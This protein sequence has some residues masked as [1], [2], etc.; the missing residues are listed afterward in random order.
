LRVRY[1]SRV[2]AEIVLSLIET[3]RK[4][5]LT[6]FTSELFVHPASLP[7]LLH[8]F[9]FP[10]TFLLLLLRSRSFLSRASTEVIR[11]PNISVLFVQFLPAPSFRNVQCCY[12]LPFLC[13][14]TFILPFGNPSPDCSLPPTSFA[15]PPRLEP[16]LLGPSRTICATP[17]HP[18]TRPLSSDPRAAV[19]PQVTFPY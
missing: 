6:F 9:Q 10:S 16:F 7:S 1:P 2:L 4:E 8:R 3:P 5:V 12:S 13:D 11:P 17:L 15:A 19:V 18:E 14:A